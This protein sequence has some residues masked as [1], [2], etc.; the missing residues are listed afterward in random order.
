VPSRADGI[1]DH[2]ARFQRRPQHPRVGA[3]GQG[4]GVVLETAGQGDEAA[5]PVALRERLGAPRRRT[6][7]LVRLDPDLE[8]GR[9]F[10]FEIVFGVADA[11]S[12]AHHLHITGFGAAFVAKAVL[13][14]DGAFA[15][16][17]DD[18]HVRMR[19][20]RKA[21]VRGDL[22]VV[23]DPDRT[24]AHA[25]RIIVTGEREVVLGVQPAVV[26]AAQTVEI[27]AFDHSRPPV[28]VPPAVA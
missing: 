4:V 25:L 8:Q 14:G 26:R 18:L 27:P 19:M 15:D 21:G 3:D 10:G 1:V 24:P 5:R 28:S 11:R 17:G 9:G 20:G 16:V 13:V 6:A 12:G 23:P 7:P 22:V 2:L